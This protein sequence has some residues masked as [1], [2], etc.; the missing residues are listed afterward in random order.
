MPTMMRHGPYRFHFYSRETREPAH[1]PVA[2]DELE[3]KFWLDPVALAGN[4][5]F[6]SR[7]L[8][9]IRK[10]VERHCSQLIS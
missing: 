10:L 1:I 7:E 5:G 8:A 4:L 6:K 2:R 9:K 3:A